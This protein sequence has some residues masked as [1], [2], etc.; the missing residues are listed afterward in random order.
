MKLRL[1]FLLPLLVLGGA[2]ILWWWPAAGTKETVSVVRATPANSSV[3]PTQRMPASSPAPE[4]RPPAEPVP[5]S[6]AVMAGA[7]MVRTTPAPAP[8]QPPVAAA[9]GA[10]KMAEK[11]GNQ[12][13]ED[14]RSMFRNFH[15]RMG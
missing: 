12:D 11:D 6:S 2:A 7:P 10:V 9:P 14:V 5:T 15:T 8:A 4:P 13:L 3:V 1:L